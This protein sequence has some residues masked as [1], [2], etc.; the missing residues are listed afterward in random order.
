MK[1]VHK[2]T[3]IIIRAPN[4]KQKQKTIRSLFSGSAFT[5]TGQIPNDQVNC[6]Y[7]VFK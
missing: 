7:I 4:H 5:H 1:F 3:H 2:Y 6:V